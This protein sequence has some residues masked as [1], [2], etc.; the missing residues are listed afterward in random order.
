MPRVRGN[1]PNLVNGVSQQAPDLRLST[2]SELDE[3][4][5]PLVVDGLIHRPPSQHL[6]EIGDA[7]I[8]EDA[9]THTILRDETEKYIVTIETDGTLR[10][11][12]FDGAEK[13]VIDESNGY[14]D[15]LTSA[16][17]QLRALTIADHTFIVNRT[18]VV[19][20]RTDKSPARPDEALVY[21]RAGNYAK[22]Y[23]IF[24]NGSQAAYYKTPNGDNA[25]DGYYIDTTYI[26]ESLLNG[27]AN[28]DGANY[29]GLTDNGYTT[30]TWEV[31]RYNTTLYIRRANGAT[32]DI[33]S[34]DG[35]SNSA[36]KTLKGTVRS[37]SDLPEHCT[38]GFVVRIAG[39]E[40][41]EAEDYWVEFVWNDNAG[42]AGTW[43]E[44]IC[45][46]TL[47]G[48]DA[49]TMPHLLV[50]NAN[51]TFTFKPAPWKDRECGDTAL[52][53]DPSFVGQ[54]IEDVFFHRNRLGIL[55]QE[56]V[57]LSA[58]GEF[59]RFYKATQTALLDTDPIDVAA[60]HVKV[61]LLRH[62]VPFQDVLVLWSDQTQFR[63]SG[64]ELLTPKTVSARPLTEM[65]VAPAV[66]PVGVGSNIFFV[67]ESNSWA[68]LYEYFVDK[69][70]EQATAESASSQAPTYIP[71]GVEHLVASPDLDVLAIYTEGEPA[72]LFLYKYYIANQ[73]KLQ[74]AWV[75]WK[76]PGVERIHSMA[77]DRSN[78]VMTVRRG[79]RLFLEKINM[80]PGQDEKVHLDRRVT[81]T[82][83]VFN[84]S[85]LTTT[86]T[87]PYPLP[88][89]WNAVT[90]G[91]G[92]SPLGVELTKTTEAALT[93]NGNLEGESIYVGVPYTSRHRFSTFFYRDPSTQGK[94][95][96]TDGRLQ[97]I[98]L[99]LSYAKA[100]YF[101]VEVTPEG[102]PTRSY[103]YTGLTVSD[104][105]STIGSLS[106]DDGRFAVP[107]M[108]RND[109]VTID[110]VNDTWRGY[111]L[112]NA[113]W[114]GLFNPRSRET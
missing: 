102:R 2:Q 24:I 30:P 17:D 80:E 47:L 97:I 84:P 64:N 38:E 85:T 111:A 11:F 83:G 45:P 41:Q 67:A 31:A 20:Q 91:D 56:N 87:A 53:P 96:V 58:A 14:L 88:S 50:R 63:L 98:S 90:T 101:R 55:T 76:L 79:G 93:F 37:F 19:T 49:D 8:G 27:G 42:S 7:D 5:Y 107:I 22:D 112:T 29:N 94:I 34:V 25:S 26:A 73:E 113:Q 61:S 69:A 59:Y 1:L 104:P 16:K 114:R 70:V 4:V 95:S 36:M 52:N 105:D 54:T 6:A 109:R 10:V 21:V 100:S 77:M 71:A 57:V 89:G 68:Q 86:F 3:N 51:G 12:D 74:S 78:L 40:G 81:L 13:V 23:K 28:G 46:D 110:V 62:A 43:R 82:N 106:R 72:S 18:K 9:F 92:D 15:G 33:S 108:S 65:I 32:F 66:K 39:P 103:V 99:S 48:F 44:T 35:Y 75:K 60:N